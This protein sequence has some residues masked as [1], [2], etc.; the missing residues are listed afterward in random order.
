MPINKLPDPPITEDYKDPSWRQWFQDLSRWQRKE[1]YWT[2]TFTNLTVGGVGGTVTH[3]ANYYK[4]GNR[5]SISGNMITNATGTITIAAYAGTYLT[6]LPFLVMSSNNSLPV[7]SF[8][9]LWLASD[10]SVG[11]QLWTFGN[12][13]TNQTRVYFTGGGPLAADVDVWWNL[14]YQTDQ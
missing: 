5:V 7:P 8:G 2:P 4:Q 6:N 9:G 10:G 12:S 13:S 3:Y 11:G 1:G 14:N